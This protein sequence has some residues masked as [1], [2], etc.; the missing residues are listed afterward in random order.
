[1]V[2]KT[3]NRTKK[4]VR[5]VPDKIQADIHSIRDN[6]TGKPR[7][8]LLFDIVTQ[9]CLPAKTWLRLK[10]KHLYGLKAG[11]P[12]PLKSGAGNTGSPP[13]M[14]EV[15]LQS[16][17]RFVTLE[18]PLQEDYLFKSRKGRKPLT[19]PS[20]SRIVKGWF[21]EA[22]VNEKG[23]VFLLRKVWGQQKNTGTHIRD[24]DRQVLEPLELPTLQE[25]V[26]KKL[27]SVILSGRIPPGQRII[28]DGVARQL[29]I[30]KIPVRE[31]LGRLHARGFVSTRPNRGYTVNSLSRKTLEEI[32]ELRIS[33]ECFAA[34]KAAVLADRDTLR[35]LRHAHETYAA[36]TGNH[37]PGELFTA[38]KNFHYTIYHAAQRP[39][40]INFI[41][42]LWD[43]VSPYYHILFRRSVKPQPE[44]GIGYHRK[45][46]SA[47]ADHDAEIAAR[48]LEVDL[49][50]ST[51]FIL[52]LHE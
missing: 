20:V 27:E 31:A 30:S 47:M 26:Y 46:L 36:A 23:A 41:D 5:T 51:A 18:R 3:G 1:M 35:Q 43:K 22:G 4:H 14:N 37:D 44:A 40:L 52:N 7:D 49:I 45:I 28:A 15:L 16:F 8:L 21:R 12:F 48:W 29:N 33:L 42:Q 2:M 32:L 10:V 6:L 50:D 34:K 17:R 38:N 25:A 24:K 9:T 19:L 11:D 13:V 39:M